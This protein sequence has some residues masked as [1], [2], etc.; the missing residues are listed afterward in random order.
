MRFKKH[1][2]EVSRDLTLW[3]YVVLQPGVWEHNRLHLQAG[4]SDK[5]NLD[6]LHLEK[7]DMSDSIVVINPH[8]YIGTSTQRELDYAKKNSKIIY[9]L[10]DYWILEKRGL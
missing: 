9:D 10:N 8:G 2:D 5:M 4:I 3:R 7:I 1:F 6:K